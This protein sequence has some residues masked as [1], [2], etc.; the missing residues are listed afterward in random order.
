MIRRLSLMLIFVFITASAWWAVSTLQFESTPIK[1]ILKLRTGPNHYMEDFTTTSMDALGHPRMQL[2]APHMAHF[3]SEDKTVLKQPNFIFHQTDKAQTWTVDA[4]NGTLLED[5]DVVLLE[6]HVFIKGRDQNNQ[7][8]TISTP[9]LRVL[10][11]EDYA[12]SKDAVHITQGKHVLDAVGVKL[13]LDKQLLLLVSNV[14]GVY[15]PES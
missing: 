12:E 14:R 8:V 11:N 7:E 4:D 1:N 5:G 6:G 2:S 15:V 3:P 9:A 10:P 13:Y